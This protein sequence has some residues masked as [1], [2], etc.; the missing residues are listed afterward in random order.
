MWHELIFRYNFFLQSSVQ[1]IFKAFGN[2]PI[3]LMQTVR[4]LLCCFN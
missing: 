4:K 3:T 2:F 1:G